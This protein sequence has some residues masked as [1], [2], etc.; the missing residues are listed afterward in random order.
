MESVS[1]L[2]QWK[3]EDSMKV[4]IVGGVAGGASAAARLRRLDE[5]VEIIMFERGE[6]V[7]FANCGLPYYIGGDITDKSLLTV[8]TPESLKA[9]F[10]IDVRILEEVIEIDKEKK[11]ITVKKL[12]SDEIYKESYDKLILSPGAKPLVPAMEGVENENVFTLRNIPD[13]YRIKDYVDR[14]N[15]ETAT[16]IG[17]GF[18]GLEMAENLH[19]LGIKVTVIEAAPQIATVLDY[20]MAM[21]VKHYLSKLG[22]EVITD[23]VIGNLTDLNAD[24]IILSVGVRPESDLAVFAGLEV[25]GRGAI[26]VDEHMRTSNPDI[27][28][29]GDAVAIQNLITKEE[30]YVPLAGPANKQGRIAADHISGYDSSYKGTQGTSILKIYD[31]T[32]AATGLG[33]R[34][35]RLSKVDYDKVYLWSNSHATY[36]P[37]ATNMSIKVLFNKEDGRI[38]GAQIVGYDGVDKRIDV[39]ATAIRANMTAIDL[40][41]LELAYA[42]PY[43]SAKDPVNMV[44]FMI[45]NVRTNKVKQYHWD[46]VKELQ[47]RD[48]ILMLDV[49]TNPERELGFIDGTIHIPLDQLRDRMTEL[50]QEKTI[51]VNCQSGL[52]S[53]LAC[54]ILSQH[55]FQCYHLAGGY[56][57]YESV[58]RDRE[59]EQGITYPCGVQMN[60]N[61]II[62]ESEEEFVLHVAQN[63]ER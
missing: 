49:R 28:A 56:R 7:S 10:R 52:R 13:T 51:Y 58:V 34:A 27:Y 32:V 37:N 44:G 50:D 26:L 36:Y 3:G 6:Y 39:I 2:V 41:E 30:G 15:P 22:I 4:L 12:T 11:E 16:V 31:M 63:V 19:K 40:S 53:Y 23:T 17:G 9:R 59:N 24:M 54:R 5:T 35:L 48:D 45:E 18:I 57:L 21:D 29:V 42:P 47:E 55:G 1:G 61:Y 60:P 62:E 33:E 46:E 14:E 25:N 8:Q 20:D 43:S 38:L